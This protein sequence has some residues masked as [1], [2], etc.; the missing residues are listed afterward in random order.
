MK[1]LVI[2]V[3]VF[4]LILGGCASVAQDKAG[5]SA[6]ADSVTWTG[7]IT[8][9]SC[10]AANANAE[11]KACALDCYKGGAKLVLYIE[12]DKKLVG[13]DDQEAAVEHL[14]HAVVVT[15]VLKDGVIQVTTIEK[16][17]G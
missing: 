14:G 16:K 6:A 5:D 7:W 17:Q 15:G 8:D 11:G 12:S 9:E 3:G 4:S 13:L 10:G 1:N 2:L